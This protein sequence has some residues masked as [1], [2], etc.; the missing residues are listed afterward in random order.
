MTEPS[1]GPLPP[2]RLLGEKKGLPKGRGEDENSIKANCRLVTPHLLYGIIKM[3]E[4]FLCSP[5]GLIIIPFPLFS[6]K[7]IE[8]TDML[9]YRDR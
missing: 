4:I 9:Y 3:V 1:S 6:G 8:N 7:E 2:N 5:L